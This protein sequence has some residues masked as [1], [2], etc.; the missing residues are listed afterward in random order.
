MSK[1]WLFSCLGASAS[2]RVRY[3][4]M[5]SGSFM[6]I[7][8]FPKQ[9]WMHTRMYKRMSQMTNEGSWILNQLTCWRKA[10]CNS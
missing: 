3:G 9:H 2:S 8:D 10:D 1:P 7:T 6:K 5:H 4:G